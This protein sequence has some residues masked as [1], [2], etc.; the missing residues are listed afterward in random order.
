MWSEDN[1]KLLF[2]I[3]FLNTSRRFAHTTWPVYRGMN[4]SGDIMLG[5]LFPIHERSN[6]SHECGRLQ[7]EGLQQLEALL[8][9]IKKI[10]ENPK[11]L[12]GVKLGV[13]ALDSCDS[14]TYALEQS[15]DFIKGF[16]ARTNSHEQQFMCQDGSVPEFGDG[17]FDRVVGI[18]G[19]QSSSVSIQL[20]NILRLFKVPQVSYQSTSPTLSNKEKYSYFF[21]TVPSD[22]NQAHAILKLL[23]KYRW[24]YVS[25]V[26]S[27]TDYGNKGYE[28]LQDLAPTYNICFSNPQSINVDHF[29][30]YDYDTVIR[31]LRQKTNARVVVVFADKRTTRNL[32]TA[33]TRLGIT[34]RFVWIGSDGWSGRNSVVENNEEVLEGAIT[35]SPLV[36]SLSGFDQY[37][38]SLTPENNKENPWF[39]EF[40][41]EYFQCQYQALQDTKW[42]YKYHHWCSRN[43]KISQDNGYT[44]TPALHFVRDAVYAFAH[45]LND[46]HKDECGGK[47]GLCESM[48][49]IEGAVLKRY[50]QYVRFTDENG[51]TFSFLPSGDAPP[52][53]SVINFHNRSD[54]YKWTN[55]GHYI[56]LT[57][58]RPEVGEKGEVSLELRENELR[59]KQGE[60]EFPRSF[61]SEPC[62]PGQRKLQGEGDTC[63]WLCTDCGEYQYLKNEYICIDCPWGTLPSASKAYCLPI[64][65]EFLNFTNPWAIGTMGFAG[66]GILATIFTSLVFWANGDTPI[67]KAAG[68]ELSYLLL[69]GIFLSYCMTFVI[70]TKPTPLSCGLTR[71]FLGFCYTLC[72]ASIVTKTNRIARI[73]NQRSHRP[74]Q[75]PRYTS[76]RSQLVITAILVSVEVVIT[77]IWL[78]YDQPTVSYIY[79]TRRENILICNGSDKVSYLVG[80]IYP[81]ILIGFC[82]IYAFKTRKCP[83]GFNEARYLTF[84]N[85]TTCV[86]WLAFLPLFV[87][88]TSTTIRA[89]TLSF[90]F[91]LSGSVQLACLFAPKVYIALLRPEKNTKENVMSPHN[92]SASH[93][94]SSSCGQLAPTLLINGGYATGN[95][96]GFYNNKLSMENAL[97]VQVTSSHLVATMPNLILSSQEDTQKISVTSSPTATS[98]GDNNNS[99]IIQ[100][101]TL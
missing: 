9:T 62:R 54:G 11:L 56:P 84:T 43:E 75:K 72:Y 5:A 59:F 53:Y 99:I 96:S 7:E 55:V 33:A 63:C 71:F 4:I 61:C 34:K 49:R 81:F 52:R 77:I 15:L 87:L 48:R 94:Q 69:F 65:E 93:G 13:V 64:P 29:N 95:I 24:T 17:S 25:I 70:V 46:L 92:K 89:V 10:N 8:F 79:P 30:D 23:K 58:L 14:T 76:P 6:R 36:R 80:L 3:V 47:V 45:A 83:D 97:P 22:V 90:L 66:L 19:G 74:C 42:S 91:S 100:N 28:K 20:A 51:K 37:F 101:K 35:I 12:P 98:C 31:N 67:I 41:E 44:Q 32:M 26:Y 57:F 2:F 78:L 16:I 40:W 73:F 39:V 1:V 82:T 50:L 88:S 21:R 86:I 60:P 18:I 85:Y 38:T 68:R 27:N